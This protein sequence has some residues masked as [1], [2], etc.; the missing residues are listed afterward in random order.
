MMCPLL[1]FPP[2]PSP[3][4]QDIDELV[5]GLQWPTK[6]GQES[7]DPSLMRKHLHLYSVVRSL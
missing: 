7:I 6:Q 3:L 2:P 4:L 5:N 1:T